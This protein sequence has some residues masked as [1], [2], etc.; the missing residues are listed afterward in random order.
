MLFGKRWTLTEMENR[1]FS[2]KEPYIEFDRDHR[3]ASGSGGCNRFFGTFEIEGSKLKLS[4]IGSTRRACIDAELQ[5]AETRFL[6]VLE[7]TTR[8]EI[9]EISW[10][11]FGKSVGSCLWKLSSLRSGPPVVKVVITQIMEGGDEFSSNIKKQYAAKERFFRIGT[12]LVSQQRPFLK[13]G[14]DMWKRFF[15]RGAR[16]SVGICCSEAAKRTERTRRRKAT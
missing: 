8:F 5:Q 13:E 2:R 16:C 9:R 10:A 3:R 14:A 4:R 11:S 1:K 15:S 7:T 12:K 6:Q